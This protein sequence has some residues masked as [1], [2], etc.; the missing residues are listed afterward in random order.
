MLLAYQLDREGIEY[1]K[2]DYGEK[3]WGEDVEK[4]NAE[5]RSVPANINV[6]S[7]S[8]NGRLPCNPKRI[9]PKLWSRRSTHRQGAQARIFQPPAL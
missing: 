2:I 5:F 3:L 9:R 8:A 1:E 4:T 6:V 7:H